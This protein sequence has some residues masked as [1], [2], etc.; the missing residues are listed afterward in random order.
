MSKVERESFIK[1][2]LLFFTS[3]SLL[4]GTLFFINFQKDIQTL[5]EKLLS[6]MQI[7]SF[8]LKC[9]E[10][11]IDFVVHKEEKLYTLYKDRT[12]LSSYY[13]LPNSTKHIMLLNLTIDKYDKKIIKIK[14]SY[15][16]NFSAVLIIVFLLS[17]LF[18]LY[19]LYP[20]RNALVL[21]Q[22]FIKDILHDFNTPLSSM[23]LN[24]SM[25]KKEIGENEKVNRIEQSIESILSL[26]KHL[27]SYL[28]K[29]ELQ[30]EE[31][32]LKSLLTGQ[33]NLLHINYQS[34]TF[35]IDVGNIN[36]TTNK[37]AFTRITDN[38]LTNAAKY[39]IE[40]GFVNITYNKNSKT[41]SIRDSGKGIKNPK[42]IFNR[43][44]KEQERGIGIGLHI[45]KK[46]CDELNIKISVKSSINEGSTFTLNLSKLT[47]S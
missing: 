34:I 23:R 37:E 36:I 29:H 31:F 6:Q 5:D 3:L 41:L 26:Q 42:L 11:R 28:Q 35:N 17:V 40:K 18:S 32:N 21:T 12:G 7:C 27:R 14:K 38:I 46:L 4:I 30:E 2:F 43:F 25:L 8:N 19:S 44:Y 45:V 15:I 24:S 1:S 20:L 22:E 9:K 47:L 39:N 33:A 16:W 13:P 10:F